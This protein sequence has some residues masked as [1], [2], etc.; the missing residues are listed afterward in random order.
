MQAK[1]IIGVKSVGIKR[2]VDIEVDSKEHLFYGNGVATSN[3]HAFAYAKTSLL[4]AYEKY[5]SPINFFT[6]YL[7]FSGDKQDK[8]EEVAGLISEAKSVFNIKVEMCRLNNICESYARNID[9]NVIYFGIKSIRSMTGVRGNEVISALNEFNSKYKNPNWMEILIFLSKEIVSTNFKAL[10]SVGFFESLNVKETRTRMLY[11]YGIFKGLKDGELKWVQDN[12]DKFKWTSLVTCLRD[13]MPTKKNGGGTSTIGRSNAIS[14]EIL[15]LESPPYDLD[16]DDPNWVLD[17]EKDLLG[18]EIS[19]DKYAVPRILSNVTC[20][21][22][23]N[24]SNMSNSRMCCSIVSINT[25][26]I[27]K[28]GANKDREMVFLTVKDDT[29]LFD[30]VVVFPDAREDHKFSIFENNNVLL[31]GHIKDGSFIVTDMKDI[32][33]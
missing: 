19:T 9:N 6:A 16:V 24:K 22:A 5:K 31:I 29:G 23:C 8:N 11:E 25:H 30:S 13:L 3:S 33:E 14:N 32:Q 17:T 2:S 12:Y 10:C 27:K 15:L 18:C 28:E 20:Q 1:R 21:E 7:E 4:T 26:T